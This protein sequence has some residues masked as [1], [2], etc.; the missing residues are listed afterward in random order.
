MTM[1]LRSAIFNILAAR[2]ATKIQCL[3]AFTAT[4]NSKL[5]QRAFVIPRSTFSGSH[6]SNRRLSGKTLIPHRK[7]WDEH[8]WSLFKGYVETN[9]NFPAVFFTPQHPTFIQKT[10]AVKGGKRKHRITN[11][12]SKMDV[13]RVCFLKSSPLS[14]LQKPTHFPHIFVK[15]PLAVIRYSLPAIRFY[16][17]TK[18]IGSDVIEL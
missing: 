1:I 8:P 15:L 2:W 5:L 7:I 11:P 17:C 13:M 6:R 4:Q 16:R 18:T 10:K 9:S 14:A 3:S 12:K